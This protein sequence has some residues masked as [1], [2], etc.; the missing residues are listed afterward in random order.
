[1]A[2]YEEFA[3]Q[4]PQTGGENNLMADDDAGFCLAD[5][6]VGRECSG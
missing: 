1:M 4:I 6:I 5:A 3:E 2:N